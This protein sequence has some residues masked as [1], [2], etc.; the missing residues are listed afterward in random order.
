MSGRYTDFAIFWLQTPK[1]I[2]LFRI[3][4]IGGKFDEWWA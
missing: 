4:L 1:M 3:L 2:S